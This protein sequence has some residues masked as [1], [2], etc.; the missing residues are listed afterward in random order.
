MISDAVKH[1]HV[2]VLLSDGVRLSTYICL[3]DE[4][5]AWPVIFGR[6][7]YPNLL[8]SWLEE[9]AYWS[10]HGY[11]FVFQECRGTGGSEGEWTPFIHEQ[12][13]GLETL[14]WIVKQPWSNGR[15]ATYGASYSGVVQWAMAD[16]LPPEV[17][18]MFI[19]FTGIERYRQNYM[20]GMF[21]H[22]IYTVWALGNA[23][24][25]P[26][27]TAH[28]LYGRALA[29]RPHIDMDVEL[30]GIRLPWYR[31]WITQV[32]PESDL[33]KHGLWAELR[34]MPERTNVPVCM[35]AGWFDHNLDASIISYGKL[36]EETRQKS[37]L[38]V[39][40]WV[41][42]QQPAGD[43]EYPDHD[44]FGKRQK[45]LAL[46]WFDHWLKE[47]PLVD[48]SLGQATAYTIREEK[49]RV[50]TGGIDADGAVKFYLHD[51]GSGDTGKLSGM[52]PEIEQQITY[53]YNPDDPAPTRGGGALMAYLTD[54]PKAAPCA[55][56]KQEP[57]GYRKDVLTF[58]SEPLLDGLRIAGSICATLTVSTDAD[59]TAFT[60]QVMEVLPD[61]TTFNIR[62][63]ITS[64]AY[65]NN[66]AVPRSYES[67]EI[68]GAVIELWPIA[69][70]IRRG[71][72]IRVD[73][74]SSNFPAYHAHPN[75]SGIWS[76]QREVKTAKQ[77]LYTGRIHA[78]WIEI[79]VSGEG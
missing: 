32:S 31:E 60:V 49:R 2:M 44:R 70:M 9:A 8:D 6:M 29:V 38:V 27:G 14:Q 66:S 35:T 76:Y 25:K 26:L 63:G 57:P 16:R 74:S 30:F 43:L 12:Q 4:E 55:S 68:V 15:L 67:G 24:A 53:M 65:R 40:P 1:D 7:P 22:D 61:G 11:A 47:K 58:I 45:L 51:R 48:I 33:W 10:E 79:P 78:S 37:A 42:T 71:S 23:G 59:D 5:G 69:W 50:W 34:S 75:V 46:R 64:L 62:D 41:H 73:I 20:N 52:A 36:P 28:D 56:V 54:D 17:K 18:T 13:D 21:R 19:A 39:G 3:P 77:T 72:R